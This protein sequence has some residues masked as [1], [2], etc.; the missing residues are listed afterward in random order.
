MSSTT[1]R[2]PAGRVFGAPLVIW[3]HSFCRSTLATYL[4]VRRQYPGEVRIVVCGRPDPELRAKAGF[5]T[6]E[7]DLSDFEAFNPSPTKACEMLKAWPG[8]IHMFC[9]YHGS[10]IFETLLETAIELGLSYFVAAEAPQNMEQNPAR[11]VMKAAYIPTLLRYKVRHYIAGSRFLLCYSGTAMDRLAQ[12]GW[13]EDKVEPFG[14]YPPS[15]MSAVPELTQNAL[16]PAKTGLDD[17]RVRFLLTGVHDMHKSP[18]TLVEA[19]SLL[20]MEGLGARFHC[21]IAG[22]GRQ[23][24]TMK[25][26]AAAGGLPV[27]FAGFVPLVAL[28]NL[29]RNA[30]VFVGTG[31]SEP[32]GIRINDAMHLGCPAIVSDGMGAVALVK[33]SGA[34]WIYRAGSSRDLAAK[35]KALIEKPAD[36]NAAR[37]A[38]ANSLAFNPATKASELVSIL[39]RRFVP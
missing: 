30:D 7:F 35:M 18:R 27:T 29:H 13:P 19:A 38:L 21:T 8:A 14:Y 5:R 17:G 36:I 1:Q 31:L 11:R 12:V 26:H 25:A 24:D 33:D 28:V 34:G 3:A 39:A 22:A 23:T 32:W 6:S 37:Q 16:A 2:H 9:A 4:E 20:V 15:I 10:P